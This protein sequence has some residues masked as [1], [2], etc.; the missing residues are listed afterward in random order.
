MIYILLYSIALHH[1]I[2]LIF[3][4]DKN[5]V[6]YER[7]TGKLKTILMRN[8]YIYIKGNEVVSVSP[9][10]TARTKYIYYMAGTAGFQNYDNV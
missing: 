7:E 3:L 1:R 10:S 8:I 9:H 4:H 2:Q 6:E 5:A